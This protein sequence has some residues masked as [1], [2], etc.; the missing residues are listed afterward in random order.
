MRLEYWEQKNDFIENDREIFDR[1]FCRSVSE[2]SCALGAEAEAHLRFA[3]FAL[4]NPKASSRKSPDDIAIRSNKNGIF[5]VFKL[6]PVASF[7]NATVV[8]G[9][10]FVFERHRSPVAHYLA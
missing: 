3:V 5:P 4:T 10:K 2:F 9:G 7:S 8:F 6:S 1:Y